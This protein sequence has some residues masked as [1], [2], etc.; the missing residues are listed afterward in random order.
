MTIELVVTLPSGEQCFTCSYEP[1]DHYI[2]DIWTGDGDYFE[3]YGL[4]IHDGKKFVDLR[5]YLEAEC[6]REYAENHME[7][8]DEMRKQHKLLDREIL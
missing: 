5:E 7:H 4:F 1:E 8:M 2:E 3:P 6:D